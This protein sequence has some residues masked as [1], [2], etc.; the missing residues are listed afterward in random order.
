MGV[1]L[2]YG[3]TALEVTV[4]FIRAEG[5][6]LYKDFYGKYGYGMG[7]VEHADEQGRIGDYLRGLYILMQAR[8]DGGNVVSSLRHGNVLSSTMEML[9]PFLGDVTPE[10][11]TARPEK[12]A[13]KYDAFVEW[14]ETHLF[15]QF[16]TEQLVE[17]SGFSYPTTLKFL[18]E[19]PTF[20]KVKKGLWEIR[21]AKADRE[22]GV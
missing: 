19:S 16:T 3:G 21:D 13:D 8:I 20:R 12:R 5:A 18:Q 6:R 2:M 4:D 9:A 22:A 14:A 1:R 10:E 11:V 17:Q 7:V 15:E